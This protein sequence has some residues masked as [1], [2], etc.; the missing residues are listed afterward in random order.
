VLSRTDHY[1]G[2]ITRPKESTAC[3]VSVCG[4]VACILRKLWLTM[5]C[6]E[7]NVTQHYCVQVNCVCRLNYSKTSV[8]I[9][10]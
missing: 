8:W 9:S 1:A 2:L 3:G 4:R 5:G 6:E 7:I 10:I